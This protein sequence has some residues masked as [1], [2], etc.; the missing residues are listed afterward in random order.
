M[1]ISS[2]FWI[3]IRIIECLFTLM[4]LPVHLK[5]GLCGINE[6]QKVAFHF[7]ALMFLSS[8]LTNITLV[9]T[10]EEFQIFDLVLEHLGLANGGKTV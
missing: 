10:T 1:N 3:S 7:I 2:H 8:D 5:E 6:Q 4:T 9:L